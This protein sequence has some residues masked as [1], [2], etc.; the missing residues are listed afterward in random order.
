MLYSPIFL[1]ARYAVPPNC[2]TRS[3]LQCLIKSSALVSGYGPTRSIR[4]VRYR[5]RACWYQVDPGGGQGGRG[6]AQ[7]GTINSAILLRACYAMPGTAVLC[8]TTPLAVRWPVLLVPGQN[9]CLVR[10]QLAPH[11][12]SPELHG[13]LFHK[14]FRKQVGGEFK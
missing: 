1:L 4:H 11:V 10:D 14:D 2:L 9:G 8:G 13:L 3:I 6:S 7:P 12:R 5:R